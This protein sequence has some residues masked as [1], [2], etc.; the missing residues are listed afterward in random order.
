MVQGL[1][2]RDL[3][4][5]MHAWGLLAI[6]AARPAPRVQVLKNHILA[7]N[8]YYNYYSPIPKYPVIGYMDPSGPKP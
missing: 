4:F 6:R 1:G 7:R 8:L 2:L 3:W 5:R